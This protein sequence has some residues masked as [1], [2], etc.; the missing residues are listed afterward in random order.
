VGRRIGEELEGF[1]RIA[2]RTV[3]TGGQSAD[4]KNMA[5]L[6]TGIGISGLS[7]TSGGAVFVTRRDG[8][9]LV[10]E[11]PSPTTTDT[12]AK[13]EARRIFARASAAWR[14]L[15]VEDQRAWL[16]WARRAK[17]TAG[18]S[19]AANAF[20]ALAVRWLAANP[21]GG[22]PPSLPPDEPFGGDA[23]RCKVLGL[24]GAIRWT[25]DRANSP[26][27]V[28]ELLA[29][30]VA[31]ALAEPRDRDLRIVERVAYSVAGQSVD[32]PLRTG[33]YAVAIR[34]LAIGTGQ[35]GNVLRLGT[36][37]VG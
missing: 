31:S 9:V 11:R 13:Q 28:T 26:G 33:M 10:R 37:R 19:D 1:A 20:R 29:V 2:G 35:A 23:V 30:R 6:K 18:A 14:T 7:G 4:T 12:P 21:G 15:G 36:V 27:V 32:V 34:F 25:A 17:P 5:K 8:S 24:A 22:S 3:A 16:L